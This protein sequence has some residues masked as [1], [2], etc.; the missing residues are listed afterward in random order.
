MVENNKWHLNKSVPITLIAAIVVQTAI[1]L[2]WGIELNFRVGS[3]EKN[4]ANLGRRIDTMEASTRDLSTQL[5]LIA[6]RQRVVYQILEANGTKI[7][8][9]LEDVSTLIRK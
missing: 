9:L 7:D 2:A 1:L 3:L 4:D 6:E 5:T 8:K